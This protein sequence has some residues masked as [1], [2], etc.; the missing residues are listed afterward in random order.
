[1]YTLKVTQLGAKLKL[2][3][4]FW[5]VLRIHDILEWIRIRIWIRG[6]S[7]WLMDPD[8]DPDPYADSDIFVIDPQD[9]NKK[10]I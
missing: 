3:A 8:S 7:L 1:M 6:F 10:Q 9:G 5:T 2:K 4:L